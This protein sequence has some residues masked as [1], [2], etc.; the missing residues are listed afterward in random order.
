MRK[1]IHIKINADCTVVDVPDDGDAEY[2][3]LSDLVGGYI[4]QVRAFRDHRLVINEEGHLKGLEVNTLGTTITGRDG[5]PYPIVGDAVLVGPV[6]GS[7][8]FTT[9]APDVLEIAQYG[10]SAIAAALTGWDGE[11]EYRRQGGEEGEAADDR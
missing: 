10:W 7:G 8:D 6:D 1:Y 11:I 4:E 2:Q 5:L 9:V 3:L